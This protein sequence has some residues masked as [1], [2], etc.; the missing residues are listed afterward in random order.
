MTVPLVSVILPT[1][2]WNKKWLSEAIDSV[3]TQT[4]KN[5]EFI[6]INDA[7]T[8][9]IEQTILQFQKRDNRIIYHKNTKNIQLT[10]TLNKW[11][12]LSKWKYIARIDDDDIWCDPTKLQKQVA[13]MEKHVDYWLCG[14]SVINI[15]EQW[16]VL[17]YTQVP[18]IDTEIKK[19]L[20]RFNQFAHASVIIRKDAIHKVGPYNP[21][22][23]G[24]EDYE[25]WLRIGTKYKLANTSDYCLK[26]RHNTNGISAKK[27]RRQ[28][29]YWLKIAFMYRKYYPFFRLYALPRLIIILIPRRLMTLIMK[30]IKRGYSWN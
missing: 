23:N 21:L 2:N 20:M 24:A 7:S 1:Y 16:N 3:L 19:K 9:N 26:Y 6:I 29:W 5:F 15:N 27:R 8:N 12:S 30:L 25:L 4:Y 18:P 22:Y 14:T 10:Q 17:S 11:I 13:F 28:W